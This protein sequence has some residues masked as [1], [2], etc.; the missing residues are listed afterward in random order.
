MILQAFTTYTFP[1]ARIA[2]I[3]GDFVFFHTAFFHVISLQLI[4]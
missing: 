3:T 4:V 1:A 2:T